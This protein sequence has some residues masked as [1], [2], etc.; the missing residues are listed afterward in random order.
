MT[1]TTVWNGGKKVMNLKETIVQDYKRYYSV[2]NVTFTNLLKAYFDT[3]SENRVLSYIVTMRLCSYF[4]ETNKLLLQPFRYR[5]RKLQLKFGLEISYKSK[6]GGGFRI[7]HG[8]G[9]VIHPNAV[10][11]RNC[12]VLQNC[13]IGNNENKSRNQVAE[14]GNN[15]SL[16]AGTK[17]IGPIKIGDNVITGANSVIVA[18]VPDNVVVAG[19]PAKIIRTVE[20]C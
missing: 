9:I 6:I 18:D 4:D 2:N 14:L 1:K 20:H 7:S 5:L 11:G 13:T 3:L 12:T 19:V 8:F 10:I 17:I 15:V 16:G